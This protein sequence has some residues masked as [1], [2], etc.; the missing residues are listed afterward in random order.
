M[1]LLVQS[2]D[3]GITR[4]VAL[5]IIEGIKKGIIRNT[6]MFM[7]MPWTEECA[8]WIKPYLDDIALGIDLNVSTGPAIL[9][10]EEIPSLV[11]DNGYYLTSS[12]N[13][14][15]DTEENDYDHVVY[16]EVYKEFEAQI[17]R[18]IELFGKK[19]DYLHGHAY[20]T[21]TTLKAQHDLA[22]KY[23]VIYSMDIEEIYGT[24][25]LGMKWYKFPPTLDNQYA[26]SLK[27]YLLNTSEDYLNSELCS[28]ICHAGYVDKEL[29]QLSSF[30]IYRLN[31]L[32]AMLCDETKQWIK[33]NNIEL[34]TYKDLVK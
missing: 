8:N 21:K 14:A 3:Y 30:N 26:S 23:G 32:E 18:Y 17:L 13:R 11:Q 20:G 15:L 22:K 12:M 5:G 34:V 4:A 16:E 27:D 2:D 29:M 10:K 9:S 1:K 33:D 25:N 6:G 24:K 31:D 28:L 7:N 19:P